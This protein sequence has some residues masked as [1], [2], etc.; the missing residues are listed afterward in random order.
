[1]AKNRFLYVLFVLACVVFSAA[2]QSRIASVLLVVA[3][4]YPLLAAVLTA[5]SLFVLKVEF[6]EKRGV[7][8]KN[9]SFELPVYVCNNFLFPYAPAEL[10]CIVPDA[11]VGLFVRKQ[12]FV[13]VAPLKR[14]RIFIPCMHRY[15]GSYQAHIMR[16]RVY[17]PLKLIR[18]SRR[19][20]SSSQLVI[21]PRKML[22]SDLGFVF[23]GEQGAANEKTNSAGNRDEF[24][25]VR[26]YLT[27]DLLQLVH[28]K[29]TAK[30]DDMMIKQYDAD[31]DRKAA[32][33]C[34]F[35]CAAATNAAAIKQSDAVVEAAVAVG[36]SAMRAEIK[37]V[38]DAGCADVPTFEFSDKHGFERFY[39]LMSV[40]PVRTQTADFSRLAEKYSMC[41]AAA[42]FLIT[43][44][45]NEEILLAAE[46]AGERLSG[47]VV[48]V[49]VNCTGKL[50]EQQSSKN[51][52][53][54]QLCGENENAYGALSE[55]ILNEYAKLYE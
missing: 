25:H 9:E 4:A 51:F 30:H 45:L 31:N 14:M 11:E 37:T 2:Y 42:M 10:D 55:Q 28:W 27:G 49:Y 53:F 33:L 41:G 46:A 21:L 18:F 13:S 29:L 7:Y 32:V 15:R 54:A 16:I 36:M 17:D 12:V 39:E 20:D 8:E 38:F 50:C 48:L 6:P 47:T 5:V 22:M 3:V 34:N 1:M 44:V 26:E 35:D 43:P 24:S 23:G 19:I 40:V 52:V